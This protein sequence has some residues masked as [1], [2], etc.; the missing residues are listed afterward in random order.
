MLG[1]PPR[2]QPRTVVYLLGWL[3]LGLTV[4]AHAQPSQPPARELLN[5]E[6]IEQKFGSYGIA[7]LHSDARL[8]VANLFNRTRSAAGDAE[9][10]TCRTFAVTRYPDD[11]A[12]AFAAEHREIVA[13]GS[14][15]AVFAAHGW[16]VTKTHLYYG[17]TDASPRVAELMRVAAGTPLALDAYV[18]EI[19]KDGAAFQYAS[20]V[21]IHHPDYLRLQDLAAIYGVPNPR[22]REALLASALA[23]AE[24]AGRK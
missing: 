15:G 2:K 20:I 3:A 5:S 19:A 14:I 22:G 7:V 6:R 4:A 1:F 13:G 24:A 12:A 11:V 8:R 10:Q 23:D 16:R 9:Q 18:L 21:E 17:E